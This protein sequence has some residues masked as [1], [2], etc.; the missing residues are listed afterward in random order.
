MAKVVVVGSTNTDM[1]VRVPR[2]PVP[3]ETV[4]GGDFRTTGGGKGANQAVAA[5]RAGGTVVFVTALGAD[6]I[7]DRTME[8]LAAEG[9]E[10]RHVRR[11]TGAP[12]GIALILV[13]EAGE[14][15]IAVAPGANAALRPDDVEPLAAILGPEDVVL[16][17]L[18]IPMATVDATA[19]IVRRC[20]ARLILNPAPARS[21]ADDLLGAVSVITPNEHEAAQLA[22]DSAVA[23]DPARASARLHERG[24]PDVM[25]TLGAAG[26]YVSGGSGATR[27]PAFAVDAVD[28]TA[29]GDVFNGALAVA[30][31]EGRT[32]IEAARF[33]SAAAAISVTRLGARESAPRRAEIDAW[34]GCHAVSPAAAP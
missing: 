24:V 10:L 16:V 23:L 18:E 2:L 5:A 27:V 34:L 33:A 32:T 12:S 31:I 15:V 25:I 22:G 1:T 21:L 30:L 9:L 26:V 14:N 8:N 7:G 19:R 17:Q 11:V 6:D 4:V 28:T 3:G 29:A 13:D 20:G